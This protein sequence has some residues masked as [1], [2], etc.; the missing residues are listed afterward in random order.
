MAAAAE[1]AGDRDTR[2][3]DELAAD[4]RVPLSGDEL[5]A[6]ALDPGEYLG[7]ARV[8]VDRPLELYVRGIGSEVG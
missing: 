1:R 2:F 5:L 8:F 4:D 3:G 6:R 7:S